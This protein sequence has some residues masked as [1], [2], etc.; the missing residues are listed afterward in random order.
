MVH[1]YI[2]MFLHGIVKDLELEGKNWHIES[3]EPDDFVWD[4]LDKSE[5]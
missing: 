5:L 1:L 3:I 4:S 2:E